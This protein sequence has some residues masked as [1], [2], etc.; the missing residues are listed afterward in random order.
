MKLDIVHHWN[1]HT[2]NGV[3]NLH[4]RTFTPDTQIG[5]LFGRRFIEESYLLN[6]WDGRMVGAIATTDNGTL[7]GFATAAL[8]GYRRA[9]LVLGDL[10]AV[11]RNFRYWRP[12][13]VRRLIGN[14]AGAS[15]FAAI[16]KPLFAQEYITAVSTRGQGIGSELRH[17]LMVACKRRG[18]EHFYTGV[19]HDNQPMR[20]ICHRAGFEILFREPIGRTIYLHKP[21]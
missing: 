12:N 14:R 20:T 17:L 11:A 4:L 5:V 6:I 13:L 1:D 19:H 15:K 8:G 2:I 3:V 18:A 9:G 7:I 21:L 10:V 16:A